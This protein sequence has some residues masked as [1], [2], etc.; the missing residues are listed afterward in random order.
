MDGASGQY[1]SALRLSVCYVASFSSQT[2]TD[3]LSD[4]KSRATPGVDCIALVI[5]LVCLITTGNIVAGIIMAS[6]RPDRKF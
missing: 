6:V 4:I 5:T 2:V 3:I 1:Y